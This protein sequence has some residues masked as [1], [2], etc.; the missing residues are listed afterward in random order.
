MKTNKKSIIFI[1]LV[2]FII[3]VTPIYSKAN[4]YNKSEGK[5]EIARIV[6]D[7]FTLEDGGGGGGTSSGPYFESGSG[8]N[9]IDNPGN[10]KPGTIQ[11]SD[12]TTVTNKVGPIFGIITTI[13]V[14]TGTLVI[15]IIGIKY[16]IGSVEEKA[17]YKKTMIPYLVGAI[18]LVGITGILNIFAG[19]ISNIISRI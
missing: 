19:V 16:M 14:V 18:M 2:L 6:P 13:G 1:I 17:E 4:G 10:Y 5:I 9:P 7:I 8:D 15:V 11:G 3:F 12:I